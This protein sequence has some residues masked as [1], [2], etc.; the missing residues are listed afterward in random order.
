MALSK[1]KALAH[2]QKQ[3][4]EIGRLQKLERFSPDFKQWQRDTEVVI[5]K[6][7]GENSKHVKDFGG[8]YY[9]LMAFT[10]GTP[11]YEFQR[12]YVN[13]LDSARAILQSLVS[14]I[15]KFWEADVQEA[16]VE[17]IVIIRRILERFHVAARQL[18]ARHDE[19]LT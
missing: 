17:A 11:D 16:N 14:E 9:S 8:I 12:A 7:F 5:V 3:I 6:A 1:D 10:T 19:R 2:L 15:E 4:G 18:R 13:G